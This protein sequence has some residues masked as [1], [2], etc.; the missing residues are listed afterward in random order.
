MLDQGTGES[1][2]QQIVGKVSIGEVDPVTGN[3][4]PKLAGKNP[5]AIVGQSGGDVRTRA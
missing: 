2:C 1:E 5:I 4:A 3:K